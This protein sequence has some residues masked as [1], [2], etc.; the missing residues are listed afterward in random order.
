MGT[1]EPLG[2][3]SRV[4]PRPGSRKTS[5]AV[6]LAL[7]RGVALEISASKKGGLNG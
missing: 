6:L 4:P 1:Y 2:L 3:G 5:G 7:D